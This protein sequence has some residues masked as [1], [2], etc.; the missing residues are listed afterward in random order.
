MLMRLWSDHRNACLLTLALLVIGIVVSPWA[1]LAA[2][3]P[4][5]WVLIKREGEHDKKPLETAHVTEGINPIEPL[6]GT[7]LLDK[8]K[9]L[10]D[11]SKSDLLKACG[12]ISIKKDGGE[13][14]NYT[15]FY[16]AL[17]EAKGVDVLFKG[18][19][20]DHLDFIATVDSNCDLEIDKKYTELLDLRPGDQF[21][22]KIG[23]KGFRL[24][25]HCDDYEKEDT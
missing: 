11:V 10:G 16:E 18:S 21:D 17:L 13:R 4:V 22:I 12:Y 24:V 15:E 25:V 14:L 23:R 7:L 6:T 19:Q 3:I 1:L 2:V 9:E 5:A 20:H 8:I